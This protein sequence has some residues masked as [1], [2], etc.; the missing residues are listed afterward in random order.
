MPKTS[1]CAVCAVVVWSQHLLVQL[2]I[3]SSQLERKQVKHWI[4]ALP[5][6]HII[7]QNREVWS[8]RQFLFESTINSFFHKTV[9]FHGKRTEQR[10]MC[11]SVYSSVATNTKWRK[12]NYDNCKHST[13]MP[14]ERMLAS[15]CWSG[16]VR[17]SETTIKTRFTLHPLAL[18]TLILGRDVVLNNSVW[19]L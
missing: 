12:D 6:G 8:H 18:F 16:K 10:K 4:I 14:P 11:V 17:L 1:P 13:K 7:K 5:G 3:S 19:V 9:G 2:Y 15:F